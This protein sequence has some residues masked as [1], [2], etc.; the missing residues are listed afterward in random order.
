MAV[1]VREVYMPQLDRKRTIRIY[2]PKSYFTS[3]KKYPVLYM[4]DGQNLFYPSDATY[5]KSWRIHE[6]LDKLA[7]AD[8]K[9][10]W[11]VVGIDSNSKTLGESRVVEYSCHS[12]YKKNNHYTCKKRFKRK[13]LGGEGEA[14]LEFI[15]KTLMP[16]INDKYKTKTEFENTAMMGSSMGGLIS[17]FASIKY[18]DIFSK[19]GALSTAVWFNEKEIKEALKQCRINPNTRFY[20]DVGAREEA[21]NRKRGFGYNKYLRQSCEIAEIL[22]TRINE[23]KLKFIIDKKGKHDENAWAIR[24]CEAFQFLFKEN[25]M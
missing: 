21:A 19:I 23:N 25:G 22:K 18:P 17:L 16:Y 4:H 9:F 8:S 20:L 14:Y 10:E 3:E 7:E 5:K 13:G 1:E 6:T 12:T 24:V 2:L 11:I 15:V